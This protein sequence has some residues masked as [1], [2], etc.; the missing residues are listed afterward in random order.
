MSGI[1]NRVI[2]NNNNLIKTDL[3]HNIEQWL[4]ELRVI[5]KRNK[6]TQLFFKVYTL[7]RLRK[8]VENQMKLCKK[9]KI[10]VEIKNTIDEYIARVGFILG[11]T[12][13]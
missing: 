6:T 9:Y 7:A 3:K 1:I 11:P 5:G 4:Y 2:D 8:L 13:D 12:V 10:R